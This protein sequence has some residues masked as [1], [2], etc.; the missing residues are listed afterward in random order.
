M[1][2]KEGRTGLPGNDTA[3]HSI[4]IAT[5]KP[6]LLQPGASRPRPMKVNGSVPK[7]EKGK[8]TNKG[9]GMKKKS[10]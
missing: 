5:S 7:W 4:E 6:E 2:P 8:F 10:Y 3:Y 1:P 9:S